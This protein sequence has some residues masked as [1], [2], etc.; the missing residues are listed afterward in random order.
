MTRIWTEPEKSEFWRGP[1][2]LHSTDDL[3][4]SWYDGCASPNP[5]DQLQQVYCR[6]WLVED[7]LMKADKMSMAASLEL[8]CPFLDHALVEWCA[9]LPLQ[10][11]V[12][13]RQLGYSSK[14]VLRDYAA[15]RLP[16]EIINRPKRGF[17]VPAYQWLERGLGPWAWDR[18][19]AGRLDKWINVGALSL[20]MQAAERG[21]RTAQHQV[22]S[23]LVL[24]HW[25]EVWT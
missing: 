5:V 8:R 11:K 17:P 14:R 18:I 24:D 7:L 4:K 16:A 21:A 3:I 15:K 1:A 25:L 9:R 22:W 2:N 12:G 10:W 20:V 6:S 13:S 23:L 19:N